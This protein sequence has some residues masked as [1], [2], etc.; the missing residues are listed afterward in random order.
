MACLRAKVFC[1]KIPSENPR[2]EEFRKQVGAVAI[3][4]KVREF[5]V[6]DNAAKEIQSSVDKTAAE[7]K[8]KESE[9]KEDIA[10][11]ETKQDDVSQDDIVSLK[12][13]FL[14]IYK[15]VKKENQALKAEEFEKDEDSNFHIDFMCAMGNCRAE[16]YGLEPMDWIQDK[17]KA[18]RIVPAKATTTAAIAGL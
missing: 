1:I 15:E 17:L 14:N 4:F 6:D 10:E 3:Q 18:G 11:E 16:G 7:L 9:N 13:E 12:E 2:T 8:K 5:V